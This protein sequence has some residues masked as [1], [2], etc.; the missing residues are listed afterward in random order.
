MTNYSASL[1]F[2]QAKK[3]PLIVDDQHREDMLQL[4]AILRP[5]FPQYSRL[6]IGFMASAMTHPEMS[7]DAKIMTV[8]LAELAGPDLTEEVSEEELMGH[9]KKGLGGASKLLLTMMPEEGN[10]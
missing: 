6:Q 2:P 7:L 5:E 8:S 1:K 4:V 10:A 9:M 3:S